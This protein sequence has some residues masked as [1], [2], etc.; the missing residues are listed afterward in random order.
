VTGTD[1]NY[2]SVWAR[3]GAITIVGTVELNDP[4]TSAPRRRKPFERSSINLAPNGQ[5]P[6]NVRI[7]D[8]VPDYSGVGGICAIDSGLWA[9]IAFHALTSAKRATSTAG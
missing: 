5:V 2:R 1:I 3:D 8:G 6:A 9:I 7:E 4:R